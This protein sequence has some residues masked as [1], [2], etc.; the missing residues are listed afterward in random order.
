M[1][2]TL[3]YVALGGAIGA[4]LRFSTQAVFI[5]QLGVN[6]PWGT[7]SVNVVG[8]FVMGLLF[9]A[10]AGRDT[11]VI[12]PFLMVGVLGGFTT[13]SAFS[14]DTLRLFENGQFG[15][16]ALYVVLSVVLSL[17]AVALGVWCAK[18]V[19]A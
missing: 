18:G 6:F 7:V 15:S 3:V 13:F 10:F 1:F 2:L 19:F 5:R 14:L 16:A 4:V 12:A 9:V 11:A 8:S 17:C